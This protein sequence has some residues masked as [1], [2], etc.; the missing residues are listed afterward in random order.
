MNAKICQLTPGHI[1]QHVAKAGLVTR[2]VVNYLD[3]DP[4]TIDQVSDWRDPTNIRSLA[5]AR[6]SDGTAIAVRGSSSD[7]VCLG[8]IVAELS[9]QITQHAGRAPRRSWLRRAAGRV[10]SLIPRRFARLHRWSNP[11]ACFAFATVASATTANLTFARYFAVRPFL[12]LCALCV[13][14]GS[15]FSDLRAAETTPPIRF[16]VTAYCPCKQCC[17]PRACGITAS[18]A[19]AVGRIVAADRRVPFGTRIRIPG[20]GLATVRDRGGAIRGNRLDVLFPTH[21]Q[22]RAWGR[23]FLNCEV[24]RCSR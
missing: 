10:R 24:H 18:G 21:A 9:V 7:G 1:Q 22:A 14:C 23:R 13:L 12:L 2:Q 3:A 17:G 11:L 15:V 4:I 20:Y 5:V 19:P 6:F 8:H 16:E